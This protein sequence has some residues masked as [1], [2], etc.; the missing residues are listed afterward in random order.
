MSKKIDIKRSKKYKEIKNSLIKELKKANNDTP[1]FLDL[2]E[3]YMALYETKTL[4]LDEIKK[5]GVYVRYQ[6]GK[7]Q[8]GYKK[9]EMLDVILKVNAQMLKILE[10]LKI[11]VSEYL[12]YDENESL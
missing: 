7:E 2:V 8:S 10:K 1:V 12:G 11:E 6:N 3:D 9:N 4:C 5:K